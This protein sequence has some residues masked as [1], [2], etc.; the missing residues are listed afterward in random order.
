MAR[1]HRSLILIIILISTIGAIIY[2]YRDSALTPMTNQPNLS[3]T[4]LG[5]G[6]FTLSSPA[7]LPN[8]L[9]PAKYTCDGENFNPPLAISGLPPA[10]KSLVLIM[11]DPDAPGRTWTHWVKWN[12]PPTLTEIHD[13]EEPSGVSGRGTGGNLTYQ[14]PCPPSGIHRY[15]FKLYALNTELFLPLGATKTEVEQAMKEHIL[16]Q[17]E[18]VGRY[19]RS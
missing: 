4:D 16:D 6:N 18:L 3:N 8:S 12:I 7:F 2:F 14:G 9:I 11:D 1:G 13:N 5:G 15:F 19:G 10:A 17:A